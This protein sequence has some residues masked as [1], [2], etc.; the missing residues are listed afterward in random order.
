MVASWP[1]LQWVKLATRR[2]AHHE[3][4]GVGRLGPECASLDGTLFEAVAA[5]ASRLV[6][7][8]DASVPFIGWAR[9]PFPVSHVCRDSGHT[10]P[11][12]RVLLATWP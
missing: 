3:V 5:C 8:V 4:V 2:L 11:G 9:G 10:T 1:K 6:E 7:R 12:H